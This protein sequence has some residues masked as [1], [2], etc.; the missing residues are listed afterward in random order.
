[1]FSVELGLLEFWLN[2]Q[3]L[4]GLYIILLLIYIFA[5]FYHNERSTEETVEKTLT[6]V[7][8]S[9]IIQLSKIRKK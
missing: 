9:V 2:S 5:R 3:F 4:W 8:Y 1:M 7:S 6:L